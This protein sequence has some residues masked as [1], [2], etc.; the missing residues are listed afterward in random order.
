MSTAPHQYVCCFLNEH[1]SEIS[2]DTFWPKLGFIKSAP[3]VVTFVVVVAFVVGGGVAGGASPPKISRR[4]ILFLFLRNGILTFSQN[5]SQ[6]LETTFFLSK[7]RNLAA[8]KK[9][10]GGVIIIFL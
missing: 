1:L 5:R 10:N 4:I 3:A 6:S 7:D 2:P 8:D 9:P